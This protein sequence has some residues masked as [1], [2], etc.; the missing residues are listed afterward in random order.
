TR[1]LYANAFAGAAT[2]VHV[3]PP[4]AAPAEP[5]SRANTLEAASIGFSVPGRIRL[6]Y[7]GTLYRH[8][9]DPRFLLELFSALL[10]TRLRDRLELHFFGDVH[11][12]GELLSRYRAVLGDR[13]IL[14]GLVD[15]QTADAAM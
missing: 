8:I 12:C 11:D 2:K 9:R 5:R 7:I 15:R 6:A 13:L 4:L 1:D 14:H 3:I 10:K